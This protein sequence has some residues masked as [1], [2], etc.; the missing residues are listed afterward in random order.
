MQTFQAQERQHQLIAFIL[1]SVVMSLLL[2]VMF[3]LTLF[4]SLPKSNAIQ[5]VE[6][7]FGTDAA[8]YGKV[9]TYNKPS[10]SPRAVDVKKS[11]DKPKTLTKPKT[12][13]P[14]TEISKV[15]KAKPVVEAPKVTSKVESPIERPDV[16]EKVKRSET[17]A[18]EKKIVKETPAAPPAK[19]ID[20]NALFKKTTGSSGSN[21]TVGKETGIGGNSNGDKPG[22]VGDQ[23]NPNGKIDAGSLYGK[24]GGAPTGVQ[25]S[26]AGWTPVS[27]PKDK[28]DSNESGKVVFVITVDTDGRVVNVRTK[29]ST[30]SPTITNFY[31]KLAYR[32][33]F[34]PEGSGTSSE[35]T[36]TITYIIKNS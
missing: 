7:N 5:Y 15:K 13:P 35:S 16:T 8:G 19:K 33:R 17:K 2:L 4:T 3:M 12:V 20:E 27:I 6:V 10:P 26:V 28:D 34:R 1:A 36:G 30:V 18:P 24:P 11:D 25:V 31:K 29:E 32:A 21:G 23:G 14:T 22:K 9:Q